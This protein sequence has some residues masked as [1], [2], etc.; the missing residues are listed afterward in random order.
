MWVVYTTCRHNAVPDDCGE[1]ETEAEAISFASEISID[2]STSGAVFEVIDGK[3]IQPFFQPCYEEYLR[4]KAEHEDPEDPWKR[5]GC[6][7]RRD[8]KKRRYRV[9][10]RFYHD[11]ESASD[12]LAYATGMMEDWEEAWDCR[13][14]DEDV[15]RDPLNPDG[16]VATAAEIDKEDEPDRYDDKEESPTDWRKRVLE[17]LP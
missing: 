8:R 13:D 7:T 4:D 12:A 1:F 6:E 9:T 3:A 14:E 15:M 5:D 11:A 17:N 16:P 2:E 10:I